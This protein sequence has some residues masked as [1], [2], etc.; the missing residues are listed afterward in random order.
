MSETDLDDPRKVIEQLRYGG[1]E[2]VL[3][4][5]L[6]SVQEQEQHIKK[7]DTTDI[8]NDRVNV[9]PRDVIKN[10]IHI[11][12]KRTHIIF[13]KI[14]NMLKD[15]L[16]PIIAIVGKEGNGK[17]MTGLY[18]A[19]L[20]HDQLNLMKGSFS[21][22]NQII[23]RVL[24]F[25]IY[26]R[27]SARTCMIFEEANE[28]LN[29]ND[30]NSAMNHAVASALRTQR[31]RQCVYIF[32]CPELPELDPR[33]KDKADVVLEM[34]GKQE[35]EITSYQLRHGKKTNRGWDFIFNNYPEWDVP[36]VPENLMEE[37]EQI[38][39]R[40]KGEWLDELILSVLRE[41][42][43]EMQEQQVATI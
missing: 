28:T 17:S 42:L 11:N 10:K 15:G 1:T 43:E 37:Y 2:D 39:D 31:K 30:Y 25:L 26:L 20:L 38:D 4:E 22:Q 3:H 41:R 9:S 19:H 36:D 6:Q 23:Y 33:I 21:P 12:G 27:N 16:S 13:S 18:M 7:P 32:I 24:P 35:A 8:F 5:L 40:F 14:A 29:K 34:T